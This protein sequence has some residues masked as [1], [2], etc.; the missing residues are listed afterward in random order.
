METHQRG[1][2]C[3]PQANKAPLGRALMACGDHVAPLRVIPM[4]KNPINPRNPRNKERLS[5]LSPQLSVS[6]KNPSG[7]FQVP[8]RRGE[9][10]SGAHLHHLGGG[11][12]EEGVVHPRG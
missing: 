4:L 8:Y 12:D 9:I 6:M 3:G 7:A 2:T 11:H 1:A 10:I 5:A